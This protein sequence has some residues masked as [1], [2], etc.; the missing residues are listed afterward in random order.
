MTI[1]GLNLNLLGSPSG[2]NHGSSFAGGIGKH[3]PSEQTID[4]G[5][6]KTAGIDQGS[7]F[8]EISRANAASGDNGFVSRLDRIDANVLIPEVQDE[9]RAIRLNAFA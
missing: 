1:S 2:M 8:A 3:N 6:F 9:F 7:K 4:T 5:I